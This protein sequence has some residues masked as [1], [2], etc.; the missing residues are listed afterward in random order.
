MLACDNG[1]IL[2]NFKLKVFYFMKLPRTGL[3]N[4]FAIAGRITFT[5]MNYSRQ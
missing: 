4:L 2:G 1:I 3:H 5:F